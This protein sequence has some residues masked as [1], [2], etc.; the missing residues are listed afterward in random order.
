[1]RSTRMVAICL[2]G[3]ALLLGACQPLHVISAN[4]D[5]IAI[6]ARGTFALNPGP[7]ASE[8]CAKYGKEAVINPRYHPTIYYFDCQ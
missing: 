8:H 1:M 3:A 4:E 5:H 6:E 7:E 2:M